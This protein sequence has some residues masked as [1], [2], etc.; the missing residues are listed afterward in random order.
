MI[1]F[2]YEGAKITLKS[3]TAKARMRLNQLRRMYP[4]YFDLTDEEHAYI[5]EMLNLLYLVDSVDGDLGFEIPLNGNTTPSNLKA[6]VDHM[7]ASDESLYIRWLTALHQA[8]QAIKTDPDLLPPDELT[9]SQKK[10]KS[11]NKSD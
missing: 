5:D 9:D 10:A 11:S 3:A 1:T 6:C 2:E 7:L 8:R 4:G